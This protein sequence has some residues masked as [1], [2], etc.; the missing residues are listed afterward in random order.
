MVI[1]ILTLILAVLLAAE[2]AASVGLLIAL[3]RRG[4]GSAAP[5]AGADAPEKS[6]DLKDSFE[7]MWQEGMNSVMSY[8]LGAARRAVRRDADEDRA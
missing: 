5:A 1:M 8:D 4:G 3:A 7:K 2:G 6:E